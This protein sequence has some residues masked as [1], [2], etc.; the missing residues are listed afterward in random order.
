MRTETLILEN[1]LYNPDYAS[2]VGIFL[3]PEYFKENPEKQIFI[4]IQKHLSEYN[5]APTREAISVKLNNREDLNEAA[6][7]RCNEVLQTLTSKTDDEEWLTKET[8]KWA[9]DQAVYNGIVES[10]SILEGKDKKA[11]KDVIPEILTEALAVSLDKSVGHSYLEDG[12]DRW[13]FY[14]QKE[15]KIPF[16]MSMLDKITNG[17]ISPKTL[18]VLLGGTGVGKTLVKTHLTSQYLK[19]GLN[20]LYITME[21]AEERIA[22]RVDAN[23]L[24]TELHDLHLMPKDVFEKKLNELEIGKL[25]VKEYPTAGAHVGNF[26]A[27]IRELKIKRDFTP[28]VIVLDYLNICASSRVKWAANMNTYIYIKSIA[29]EIRGLAV[30]CNVPIITSSQLNR[31]GFTSSDPDLSNT[32]ESFGL[33]AT[34]DLM[35][36]IIAKDDG[37][38]INNQILFKQLKNRYSDISMNSKFLVNV[39]KKKMKLV[40]IE[41]NDQPALANDGSNKYYEKKSDANTNSNPYTLKIK[42][43][44]RAEKTYDDWKI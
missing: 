40:D 14:H 4:E 38:G 15:T 29:E 37:V 3:K 10:I 35:L 17:G 13:N 21:M 19:Q 41:E 16:K 31:E 34:A 5:K 11:S 44:R 7:N 39:I 6:F 12:E 23:L 27:L 32:S 18:T 36:A 22:E 1:L 9:K 28:Q 26:R 20:V 43:Q 25:V 24:D 30:E 2:I 8:E 33:P 42:P